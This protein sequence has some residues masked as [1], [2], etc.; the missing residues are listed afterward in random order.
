M[1]LRSSSFLSMAV[2]VM[3]ALLCPASAATLTGFVTNGYDGSPLEAV[4]VKAMKMGTEEQVG[5]TT[6]TRED[7]WYKIIDLKKG[8]ALTVRFEKI[9]FWPSPDEKTID[10]LQDD[11]AL[12]TELY[13]PG[14]IAQAYAE[15]I[16]SGDVLLHDAVDTLDATAFPETV[17]VQVRSMLSEEF[18]VDSEELSVN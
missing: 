6:L 9:P 18:S 1:P 15:L 14:S 16:R 8:E 5:K 2:L 11:H 3:P 12:N 7:G 4:A 13:D 17:K 10:S